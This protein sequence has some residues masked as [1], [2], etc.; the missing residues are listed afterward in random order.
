MVWN[1]LLH[2]A[3]MASVA[4]VNHHSDYEPDDQTPPG[5]NRK[6]GHDA[7]GNH[8]AQDWDQRHQRRLEWPMQFGAAHAQNPHTRAYNDEGQQR[9]DA[10][11]LA[12][13]ADGDQGGEDCHEE[14]DGDGR[15][16]GGAKP[17]MHRAGPLR[18]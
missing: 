10:Y 9:A 15:D 11:Q 2:A 5:V 13:N 17:T 4:E 18:Q 16:P 1:A 8:D 3:V 6:A 7:K 14:S 12:Q